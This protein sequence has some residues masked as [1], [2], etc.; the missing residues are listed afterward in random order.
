MIQ[1]TTISR[2]GERLAAV[3]DLEDAAVTTIVRM[4]VRSDATRYEAGRR[5]GDDSIALP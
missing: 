1:K 2:G 3:G 5:C 4:A